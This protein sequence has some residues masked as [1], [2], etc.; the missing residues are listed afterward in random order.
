[1]LSSVKLSVSVAVSIDVS[2]S[3]VVSGKVEL[4]LLVHER[5]VG[6]PFKYWHSSNTNSVYMPFSS[7]T[8]FPL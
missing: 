4:V 5:M 8:L 1:V 6:A 3:A 7:F 2:V